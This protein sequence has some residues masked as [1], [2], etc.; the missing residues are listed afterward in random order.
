[1]TAPM[2]TT[3]R[4]RGLSFEIETLVQVRA[5]A[6]RNGLHMIVE[7]DHTLGG[8]EYE[9]VLSLVPNG[10]RRSRILLW[11]DRQGVGLALGSQPAGHY[12]TVQDALAR[13]EPGRPG[14]R[15]ALL[16]STL[17]RRLRP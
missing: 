16:P 1:M 17:R 13:C 11:Q 2:L 3:P 14:R 4:P 12:A 9:E 6:E 5:W 7:L 8:E 15:L 10:R